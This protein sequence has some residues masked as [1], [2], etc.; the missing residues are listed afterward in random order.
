M[1]GMLGTGALYDAYHGADVAFLL[2]GVLELVP[3]ALV[4][5][6]GRRLDPLAPTATPSPAPGS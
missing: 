3:L 2:A 4:A 6:L 5:T 1:S